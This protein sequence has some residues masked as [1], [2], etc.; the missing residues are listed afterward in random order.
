[1]LFGN[2]EI[3]VVG[4]DRKETIPHC[5]P[6]QAMSIQIAAMETGAKFNIVP[7]DIALYEQKGYWGNGAEND[8]PPTD[9]YGSRELNSWIARDMRADP[10][11]S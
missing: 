9:Y 6:E 7:R 4:C 3:V 5:A 1:M 10:N 8:D 11:F 2:H